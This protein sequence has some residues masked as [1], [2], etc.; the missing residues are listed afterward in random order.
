MFDVY[1]ICKGTLLYSNFIIFGFKYLSIMRK[2]IPVL[3]IFFIT[4]C[5]LLSF[6]NID[7]EF[8]WKNRKFENPVEANL[9]F[10]P[11]VVK[12]YDKES[13]FLDEYFEDTEKINQFRKIFKNK[14][15]KRNFKLTE[16]KTKVKIQVDSLILTEDVNDVNVYSYGEQ[17]Y[18]GNGEEYKVKLKVIGSII[19]ENTTERIETTSKFKSAPREGFLVKGFIANDNITANMDKVFSNF[20]N[21]FSY[22]CY[23]SFQ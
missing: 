14:L 7:N 16:E 1:D 17:E 22:H 13:H 2:I 20:L 10:T 6:Q 11:N 4:S 12:N 19:K 3:L 8:R 15:S 18:I 21:E 9:V 5:N 23:K